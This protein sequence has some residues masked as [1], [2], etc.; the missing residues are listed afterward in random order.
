MIEQLDPL[1]QKARSRQSSYADLQRLRMATT[2]ST[3]LSASTQHSS[4]LPLNRSS[5]TLD[6]DG[7]HI[8]RGGRARKMSLSDRVPVERIAVV[9][10]QEPFASATLDLNDEMQEGKPAVQE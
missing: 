5:S 8:R 10:R 2:S 7:L 9:D 3:S 1:T 6:V 4:Q